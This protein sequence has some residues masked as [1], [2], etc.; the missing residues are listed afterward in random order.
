MMEGLGY[1]RPPL[2]DGLID[3]NALDLSAVLELAEE[4]PEVVRV[5]RLVELMLAGDDQIDW[6]AGYAALEIIDEC[7]RDRGVDGET[8][9]WW[10]RQERD[11]FRQMANSFDAVGLRARHPGRRYRAP[12]E[13]MSPQDGA[14]FVRAVAARWIAWLLQSGT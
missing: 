5:L 11:R 6:A 4:H 8:L 14:W 3:I 13:R 1:E 9:G 10:I 2:P 7:A 12:K